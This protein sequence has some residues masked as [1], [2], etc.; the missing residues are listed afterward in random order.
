LLAGAYTDGVRLWDL[1]QGDQVAL[2]PGRDWRAAKFTRDGTALIVSGG[3]GLWR[4]PIA[5]DGQSGTGAL[6]IG[7][8]ERILLREGTASG[9]CSLGHDGRTLAVAVADAAL[10]FDLKAQKEKARFGGHTSSVGAVLSPDGRW[11]ACTT[12]HGSGVKVFDTHSGKLALSVPETNNSLAAFSP[13]GNWLA[14]GTGPEYRLWSVGSW[15]PGLQIGR[16]GTK[17]V[18]GPIAFAPDARIL[19]IVPSWPLVRLVD[20]ERGVELAT[21]EAPD[22]QGQ[23]A[24]LCFSPDG[25]YLVAASLS[26]RLHVWDLRLIRQRLAAMGL[27]WDLPPYAPAA[28]R[29]A[30]PP[31]RIEVVLK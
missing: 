15:E 2:L 10:V 12:W 31:L 25:A 1:G 24:A 3:S 14:I 7:P 11:L 19:A 6:R 8:G 20:L 22:V 27:D 17:D 23:T 30:S 28:Q 21:L 4:W 18:T 29:V 9:G 5:R 13:D 26:R 16:Q